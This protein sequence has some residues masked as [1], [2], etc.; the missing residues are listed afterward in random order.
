MIINNDN[1]IDELKKGNEKSL[2][3]LIDNYGWIINTVINKYI[4][5]IP[6][7]GEECFNDCLLGIWENISSYNSE[8]S[9]FK[10]WVGVIARY[11]SI[12]YMRKYFKYSEEKN[13]DDYN[14]KTDDKSLDNLLK[15]E[16]KDEIEYILSFLS[17]EDKL[18]F[19]K[20]YLN[21]KT[22]EEISKEMN[23]KEEVIFNRLSRGR[24][25]LKNS[26]VRRKNDG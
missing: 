22:A 24:K 7:Y 21:E 10:N 16:L 8:K 3:Y 9:S 5:Y 12:D 26:F 11:K 1:F 18:I 4:S 17:N 6:E 19:K 13:I 2:D 25:K 14:L 15:E 20:F 23:I